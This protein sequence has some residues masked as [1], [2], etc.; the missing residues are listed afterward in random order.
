M[1]WLADWISYLRAPWATASDIDAHLI[2]ILGG[3]EEMNTKIETLGV[4]MAADRDLLNELAADLTTLAAPVSDLISAHE[5]AVARIAEL[6]GDAASDEAGDVAAIGPVRDAFNA[7]ADKFKAEPEVPDVEPLPE[8]PAESEVP[9]EPALLEDPAVEGDE[10][11]P[12]P[13]A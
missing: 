2:R 13:A 6:E 7:I 12:T 3:V 5:A 1:N 11:E 8:A 4:T 9:A 10:G